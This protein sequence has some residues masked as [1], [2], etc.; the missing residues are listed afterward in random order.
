M[1]CVVSK[2]VNHTNT[3]LS[4]GGLSFAGSNPKSPPR[5]SLDVKLWATAMEKSP[6][7]QWLFS[8]AVGCLGGGLELAEGLEYVGTLMGYC[9]NESFGVLN[10]CPIVDWNG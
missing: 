5:R 6:T 1:V 9:L 3:Q 10:W 2:L 4:H 8:D 7:P